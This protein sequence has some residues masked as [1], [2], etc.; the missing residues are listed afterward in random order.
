MLSANLKLR[1]G[2]FQTM[3]ES[4]SAVRCAPHGVAEVGQPRV[5]LCLVCKVEH[6]SEAVD[7]TSFEF[8]P[9][10]MLLASLPLA[11]QFKDM[12]SYGF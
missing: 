1:Y 11:T 7:G 3:K 9:Y 4:H 10:F 12:V 2:Q 5:L 6:L 8:D